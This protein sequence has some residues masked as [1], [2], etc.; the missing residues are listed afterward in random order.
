MKRAVAIGIALAMVAGS[1]AQAADPV[2]LLAAGNLRAALTDV[3]DAWALES[4]G[5]VSAD[6][7]PSGLL[8]DRI[9][10]GE[11]VDVFA[12]VN[13]EHPQ[14]IAAQRG[15]EVHALPPIEWAS[16]LNLQ[17]D[18]ARRQAYIAALRAADGHDIAPLLAFVGVSTQT[19]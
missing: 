18:N 2:R 14:A 17:A 11:A 8:R 15:G 9:L 12:S 4:S 7:A 5:A 6:L 16:G 3:A 19:E 13:L 1:A 10:G